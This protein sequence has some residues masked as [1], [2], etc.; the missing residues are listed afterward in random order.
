MDK[1]SEKTPWYLQKTF[2]AGLIV[3]LFLA[4]I[5]VGLEGRFGKNYP[6][7][8]RQ[9]WHQPD[10]FE[11]QMD[12][13]F[14]QEMMRDRAIWKNMMQSGDTLKIPGKPISSVHMESGMT[15]GNGQM[16]F[17]MNGAS[18]AL[19]YK[20]ENDQ[21]N[22]DLSQLAKYMKE[23]PKAKVDLSITDNAKKLVLSVKNLD[24][25][26]NEQIS[27]GHKT[28]TYYHLNLQIADENGK[29]MVAIEQTL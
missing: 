15:M 26:K 24:D 10:I 28:G 11:D 13:D 14:D 9:N 7:M 2:W 12:W 20:V 6:G 23:N 21:L 4:A 5:L 29:S 19:P 3:G 1:T 8:M 25:L 16:N 17:N 27:F 22:L 18:L